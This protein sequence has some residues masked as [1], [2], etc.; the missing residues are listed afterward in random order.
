MKTEFFMVMIPP[1]MTHQQ[2]KVSV[3]KSGPKK[4][5]LRF[6][7]DDQLKAVRTN[8]EAHLAKHIPE[9]KYTGA[10]R[11]VT[12][13]CFPITGK[14]QD[15]EWKKTKPDTDNMIKMFKDVCTTLG[16]WTDDVLV[17]SD[18]IEKFWAEIPGIFVSIE[19][20]ENSGIGEMYGKS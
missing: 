15:G 2:K 4:G 6:Y 10:V 11:L 19:D 3:I 13:W 16:Y 17:T 18:I 20:L 1:T 8:L 12:K 7:E 5:Q 14:H 9:K